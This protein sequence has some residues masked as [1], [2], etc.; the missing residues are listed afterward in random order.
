MEKI[1]WAEDDV[2]A[3]HIFVI[4]E[5]TVTFDNSRK[6]FFGTKRL[7]ISTRNGS[8]CVHAWIHP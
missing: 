3:F 2:I 1:A 8:L 6:H 4:W 7:L 5:E